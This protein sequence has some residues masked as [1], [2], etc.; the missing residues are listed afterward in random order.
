MFLEKRIRTLSEPESHRDAIKYTMW[1]KKRKKIFVNVVFSSRS[2][3]ANERFVCL[4]RTYG[5]VGIVDAVVL[6]DVHHLI[7]VPS[8]RLY[9]HLTL[10]LW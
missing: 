7:D 6:L 4:D 8:S 10:Q 2:I 1:S 9:F 3:F 5:R